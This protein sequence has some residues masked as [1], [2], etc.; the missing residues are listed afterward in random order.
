MAR[1]EATFEWKRKNNNKT[2]FRFYFNILILFKVKDQSVIKEQGFLWIRHLKGKLF[3]TAR[4]FWRQNFEQPRQRKN[5]SWGRTAQNHRVAP[6]CN[7]WEPTLKEMK[8]FVL[9]TE[10]RGTPRGWC[11][12]CAWLLHHS[13]HRR[14][15]LLFH[16]ILSLKK[17]GKTGR[18]QQPFQQFSIGYRSKS[19]HTSR[20]GPFKENYC[21]YAISQVFQWHFQKRQVVWMLSAIGRDLLCWNHIKSMDLVHWS[22]SRS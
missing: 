18:Q 1:K 21:V 14:W 3:L 9:F 15:K 12:L 10:C 11:I 20:C 4:I 8:V 13:T 16:Q 5:P 6:W 19:H 17:N 22:F 2:L 7:L